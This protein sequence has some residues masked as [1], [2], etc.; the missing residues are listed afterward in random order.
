MTAFSTLPTH[1]TAETT[2]SSAS[3]RALQKLVVIMPA[4]NEAASIAD[5]LNGIPRQIEGISAVEIVVVDDGSQD[6]TSIIARTAGAE[7]IRHKKNLGLGAAFRTGL[8]EAL[9]RGADIIVN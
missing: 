9:R 5:V 1:D 3:P 6:E 2:A 7:V 4:L 8:E